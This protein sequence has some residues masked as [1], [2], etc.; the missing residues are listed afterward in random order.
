[1]RERE[2]DTQTCACVC[3]ARTHTQPP[4][5]FLPFSMVSAFVYLH[6]AYAVLC[7]AAC[8]IYI[9][10]HIPKGGGEQ[11]CI[12]ALS[13]LHIMALLSLVFIVHQIPKGGGEQGSSSSHPCCW[14]HPEAKGILSHTRIRTRH[15]LCMLLQYSA[16]IM[17]YC[18][19]ALLLYR[20]S[21]HFRTCPFSARIS[22]VGVY[23]T[24]VYKE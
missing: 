6:M 22:E 11:G 1:M 8:C 3:A 23:T 2:P 13:S 19:T 24:S 17:Y 15:T 14:R 12:K 10:Y 9:L 16:G 5:F 21:I 7:V 18:I 20:S 4:A